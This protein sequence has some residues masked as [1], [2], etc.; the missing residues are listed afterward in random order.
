M[1]ITN[2]WNFLNSHPLS[3]LNK[4]RAFK[5]FIG[6]QFL[7]RL[8]FV[9]DIG[10]IVPFIENIKIVARRGETGVTGN[11]Y[12]GLHEFVDMALVLHFL[13]PGDFFFDISAN[14][15]SY[16]LIGGV[17][18]SQ[19]IAVEAVTQTYSKLVENIGI[20]NLG[21][22]IFPLRKAVG[23]VNAVGRVTLELGSENRILDN[24]VASHDKTEEV[25]II[26]IDDLSIQYG[27]P[28]AMKVDIEGYEDYAFA[29]AIKTLNNSTLQLLLVETVSY[30]LD[31][32]LQDFGFL[33]VF[34]NPFSRKFSTSPDTNDTK[35]L[36]S[37]NQIY[38]RDISLADRRVRKSPKYWICNMGQSI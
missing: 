13:K 31:H 4:S 6:W 29:G 22:R 34:Y 32:K 10:F 15:G 25:Q 1:N 12:A 27:F 3:S 30:E 38:V 8:P 2:T 9:Q 24:T 23:S 7:S 11:L 36:E 16:T 20:N 21:N 18:D 17:C 37:C 5:N 33:K 26:T 14:V 19:V 28:V 35:K